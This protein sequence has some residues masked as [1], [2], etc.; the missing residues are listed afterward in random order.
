MGDEVIWRLLYSWRRLAHEQAERQ[1]RKQQKKLKRERR[2]KK[3]GVKE[4][5]G[6]SYQ[7]WFPSGMLKY[8]YIYIIGFYFLLTKLQCMKTTTLQNANLKSILNLKSCWWGWNSLQ[9]NKYTYSDLLNKI[10]TYCWIR[11][12]IIIL[13]FWMAD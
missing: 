3:K 2:K 1:D 8:T 9:K 7:N 4:K 13:Y 12:L 11:N 6:K 10:F 5:A